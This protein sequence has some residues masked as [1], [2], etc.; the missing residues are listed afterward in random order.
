MVSSVISWINEFSK[1][2]GSSV[3]FWKLSTKNIPTKSSSVKGKVFNFADLT[4]SIILSENLLVAA[5]ILSP[6][7][8]NISSE[9][10]WYFNRLKFISLLNFPV[11]ESYII[12]SLE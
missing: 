10:L 7:E 3:F 12:F 9:A 4:L 5:T 6:E 2:S 8:S 11:S 1:A